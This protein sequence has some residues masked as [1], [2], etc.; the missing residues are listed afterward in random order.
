MADF[1]HDEETGVW[2]W[3]PVSSS[4]IRQVCERVRTLPRSAFLRSGDAI[5]LACA[6]EH[7]F[8]EAYTNGRHMLTGARYFGFG[9]VGVDVVEG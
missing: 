3:L 4:L 8:R 2:S 9:L 6:R 5:H 1:A 7:G